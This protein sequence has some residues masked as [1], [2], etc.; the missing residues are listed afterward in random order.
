MGLPGLILL[1]E[2]DIFVYKAEK[3]KFE[4]SNEEI[5]MI[6]PPQARKYYTR[7]EFKLAY[8]KI[9]LERENMIRN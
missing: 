7:E 6:L 3:I 2:D 1:L 8:K 9:K 5:N 4:L